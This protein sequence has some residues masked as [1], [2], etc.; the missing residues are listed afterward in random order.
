MPLTIRELKL[1]CEDLK[2]FKALPF[3]K[4]DNA[5]HYIN[6]LRE[7]YEPS[8]GLPYEGIDV[9]KCFQ[10]WNL[11]EAERNLLWSNP[12]WVSS[13]K[14]NGCRAVVHFVRDVGIFV[15]SRTISV[16]NFR[17]N[18]LTEKLLP[19]MRSFI[20]SFSAI[21]DCEVL[22]EKVI[23]TH[24]YT[25]K[26]EVTKS[27]L[28]STTSIL[29]L[30]SEASI[31][32]Q[33]DQDA[34]LVF[35][36]FDILQFSQSTEADYILSL[37]RNP[38][39]ERLEYLRSFQALIEETEIRPY[40]EFV[41]HSTLNKLSKFKALC[42]E[43][44]EGAILKNLASHYYPPRNRLGWVKFKRSL[45]C[46]AYVSGFTRGD[47]NRGNANKVGSLEFSV[48]LDDAC[49]NTHIIG[50][51]PTITDELR[52][53]ISIYDCGTDTVTM[54]ESFYGKVAEITGMEISGRKLRLTHCVISKW[55]ENSDLKTK[56]GCIWKL[57]DIE[58]V[59]Q[60]FQ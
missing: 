26:G 50:Y 33:Q 13:P 59:A 45:E 11:R 31:A 46:D 40:F 22:V 38:L 58:K 29:H 25:S 56:E 41:E 28:H 55:R 12:N 30:N 51:V 27:S 19:V 37:M 8:V 9:M 10:S 14:I 18:D 48:Y 3:G 1:K 39:S 17:H 49:I 5:Q 42:A 2:L 52:D 7:H 32:I 15:Q 60:S 57:A 43:G 23:D 20:P 53:S 34:P 6:Q 47:C 35:H 4:K 44:G 21:I 54:R 16:K 24:A 36:V